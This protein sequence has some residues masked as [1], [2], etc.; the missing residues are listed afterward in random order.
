MPLTDRQRAYLHPQLADLQRH[1]AGSPA[2][3]R[4]LL[5]RRAL[6][7]AEAHPTWQEWEHFVRA[8]LGHLPAALA[9]PDETR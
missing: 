3:A 5:L 8:E 7:E 1:C 2:D 4:A 9:R 6:D